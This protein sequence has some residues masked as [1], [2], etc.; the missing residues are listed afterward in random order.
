MLML[1]RSAPPSPPPMV[2]RKVETPAS[3]LPAP[4]ADP[5]RASLVERKSLGSDAI[6][7]KRSVPLLSIRLHPLNELAYALQENKILHDAMMKIEAHGVQPRGTR[8]GTEEANL[9]D[10]AEYFALER[11]IA[12]CHRLRSVAA[13]LSATAHQRIEGYG[14]IETK[15]KALGSLDGE[16]LE[17]L[18]MNVF[19]SDQNVRK[20]VAVS[21]KTIENFLG[22]GWSLLIERAKMAG[23]PEILERYLMDIGRGLKDKSYARWVM[24][25]QNGFE[26]PQ[27][28]KKET[29]KVVRT[30]NLG[31]ATAFADSDVYFA[32]P[33]EAKDIKVG[34]K[35][36]FRF[37][38]GAVEGGF[39]GSVVS[40][41]NGEVEVK[42]AEQ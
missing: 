30:I 20:E 38:T 28:E 31:M 1:P 15:A 3:R 42:E 6:E 37:L 5:K 9:L 25:L 27:E 10:E 35:Y 14:D 12:V 39:F 21:A 36:Y 19:A 24:V 34:T 40:K 32:K 17:A 4:S 33:V 13:A 18:G 11:F 29:G 41:K 16:L 23:K 26:M 7:S 8:P 2:E 22:Q